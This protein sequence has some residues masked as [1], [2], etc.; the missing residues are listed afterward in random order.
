MFGKTFLGEK[1]N[2]FHK[3]DDKKYNSNFFGNLEV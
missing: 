2:K 1:K 3:G